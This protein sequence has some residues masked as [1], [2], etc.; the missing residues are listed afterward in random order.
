VHDASGAAHPELHD[1]DLPRGRIPGTWGPSVSE[2]NPVNVK[3]YVLWGAVIGL[4]AGVVEPM[5]SALGDPDYWNRVVIFYLPF[6]FCG[7][8]FGAVGG[9]VIAKRVERRRRQREAS[10]RC[11]TCG[12]DLTGNV[13]GRCP[14]C[15][16]DL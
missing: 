3:K 15:G 6:G 12:Y 7:W 16:T 9:Y 14:E 2:S 8:L 5:I 11:R 4:V 10:G 13:S 1:S